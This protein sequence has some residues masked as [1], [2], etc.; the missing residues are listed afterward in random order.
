[1]VE[2]S[3]YCTLQNENAPMKLMHEGVVEMYMQDDQLKGTMISTFFWMPSSFLGGKIDG[4]NFEFDAHWNNPCQ[5]YTMHVVGSVKGDT[6]T[7]TA[8]TPM[9]QWVL[10]GYRVQDSYRDVKVLPA[11]NGGFQRTL[12][13]REQ[14]V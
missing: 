12:N 1:M 14:R 3:Y 13:Q 5:Q 6:L 7:G 8:D 2:G 9:G 10:E 11:P 4:D